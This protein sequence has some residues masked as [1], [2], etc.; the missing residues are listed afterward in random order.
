MNRRDLLNRACGMGM[1]S[2]AASVM[3]ESSGSAAQSDTAENKKLQEIQTELN[4]TQWWL[5]HGAKQ[6]ARLWQLLEPHLDDAKRREILE[7]LGRNCAKSIGWGEKYKGNPEGFFNYM[8]QKNGETFTYD[9]EKGII[10]VVTRERECE[11][12]LVNS[13]LTPAYFC[14]CSM[15]WQKQMYET[16]LGKPVETELKESVL[17]GSKR[18]VFQ[19]HIKA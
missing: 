15:G 9:K 3:I 11:C 13:K 10:D 4:R 19:I 2:C 18:C 1:C 16:I 7:Q 6:L 17:Q 5:D 8:N 12:R 14:H